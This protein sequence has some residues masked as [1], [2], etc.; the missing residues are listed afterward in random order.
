MSQQSRF[1]VEA[2]G[3]KLHFLQYGSHGPQLL[4]IPGITSPAITW[5]FV[6][7]RLAR[8]ARITMLDN[9]GRGC[10]AS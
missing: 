6:G 7:E 8:H 2:K 9:R 1:H 4:L 3:I 5:A 10:Q